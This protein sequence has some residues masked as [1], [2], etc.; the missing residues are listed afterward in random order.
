MIARFV[1]VLEEMQDIVCFRN[2]LNTNIVFNGHKFLKVKQPQHI[3]PIDDWE[4]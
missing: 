2:R 3:L 1:E 4:L